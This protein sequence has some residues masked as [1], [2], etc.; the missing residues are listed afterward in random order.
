MIARLLFILL[1]FSA[2]MTGCSKETPNPED[3]GPKRI[4]IVATTG[5]VADIVRNVAGDKAEVTGII[6]EG[7]DP[8]LYKP[9]RADVARL[10][11]A[12]VVFYSGLLLE[13]KMSEV[14]ENLAKGK[15]VHAVTSLVDKEYLLEPPEFEGHPDPHMW[16]DVQGWIKAVEA[17]QL[18][19][20]EY[21]PEN[22]DLYQENARAYQEKLQ[23]LDQY[24]RDRFSTIPESSRVMVT[25]HDAFNYLGRAYDLEVI[26]I[27]GISTESE[28]GLGDLNKLVDLIVQRKIGAVFVETSVADKNVKALIEGAR[29]RG[30]EVK[31]GGELFSDAMGA[32][33]TY[34][35]TYIGMID[36][37]V[38]TIVRALGGEA[39]E[40][41]MDGKLK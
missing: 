19:M 18:A 8:H 9:T 37:N 29:A 11:E 7:V 26:G 6:G 22:K 36:H 10:T 1:L 15:P 2:L 24:A 39:P 4:Q 14:L 5:M 31:V 33:G 17:V 38:T 21:D 41:G 32:A 28:A 12:D 25:A 27:Q 40:K 30:H 16:M 20:Q 3:S 23:A 13:G 34:E 35:G